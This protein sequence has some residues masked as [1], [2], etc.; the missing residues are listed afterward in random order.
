NR[1]HVVP[2]FYRRHLPPTVKDHSHHDVVLLCLGC[3]EKYEREADALK[4]ELGREVGVPPHG[5]RTETDRRQGRAVSFARALLR[6]GDRIPAARREEML[7][8]V[9]E[10]AGKWPLADADLQAIAQSPP[11]PDEGGLI[12]HGRQVVAG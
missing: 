7:R 4:A 1:H 12:E 2:S 6:E 11:N 5:L 3:H 8:S 10:W 9:G